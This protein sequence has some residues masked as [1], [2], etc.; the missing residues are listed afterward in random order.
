M[1]RKCI[2]SWTQKSPRSL[3]THRQCAVES[4]PG[5][6]FSCSFPT[7][8]LFNKALA[9]TQCSWSRN[10]CRQT[11]KQNS[12]SQTAAECSV[13]KEKKKKK[14]VKMSHALEL[15]P[16]WERT[17][18]HWHTCYTLRDPSALQTRTA[19]LFLLSL[20]HGKRPK[21]WSC[22][23]FVHDNVVLR[24]FCWDQA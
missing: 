3:S 22:T 2:S 7:S 21:Q 4:T 18:A 8:L 19:G 11:G 17:T 6:G 10:N 5:H 16:E 1:H 20:E 13:T 9:A 12:C 23:V 14:K 15:K 24:V